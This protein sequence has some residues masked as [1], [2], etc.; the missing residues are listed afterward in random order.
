MDFL[1]EGIPERIRASRKE[2][3]E[4]PR[5]QAE[6]QISP[7]EPSPSTE[8]KHS[9]AGAVAAPFFFLDLAC[10]HYTYPFLFHLIIS[11]N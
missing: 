4:A 5:T 3:V 8:V 6:E 2:L 1:L 9:F 7:S 10:V 11:F